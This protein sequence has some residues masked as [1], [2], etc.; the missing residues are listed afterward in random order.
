MSRRAQ[1][2]TKR[3]QPNGKGKK[4]GLATGVFLGAALLLWGAF[5]LTNEAVLGKAAFEHVR[6]MVAFGPRPP[7][8][9]AHRKTETYI[10]QT[11]EAAG[12]AVEEDRF[13]AGTPQGPIPMNNIVGKLAG[14]DSR[15]LMLAAHY[16]TKRMPDFPFVGANDGGSGTGL[17]LALA[18]VLAQRSFNHSIWLVFFDGEE[19]FEEWSPSDSLYG[20]RRFAARLRADGIIPRIGAFLLVDMV[21]DA[22]LG[23]LRESNSTPWLRDLVWRVAGRLGHSRHFLNTS[24][25]V[26]DDHVPLIQAGAP[27][28]DLIDFDY[29]AGNRYWHSPEDTLDKLSPQ[30]LQV[31]GEVLLEVIA[32]L[33]R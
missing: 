21:G 20:S 6:Q 4:I 30:S 12:F 2:N 16:D 10:R 3:R 22:D 31:V 14:R 29:G 27:A 26:E 5:S 11:L 9:E 25:A 18:P 23:I 7:G 32:E 24:A 33:D 15:I 8:S 13:T 19:A 1:R 17:L 28:V